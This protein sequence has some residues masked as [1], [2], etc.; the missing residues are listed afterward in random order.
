MIV[1]GKD[2]T[3]E[4]LRQYWG[5]V[6]RIKTQYGH[7]FEGEVDFT[8]SADNEP[9]EASLTIIAESLEIYMSDIVSIEILK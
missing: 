3:E 6:V 1:L 4:K 7:I 8:S 9:D 5:K 2:L